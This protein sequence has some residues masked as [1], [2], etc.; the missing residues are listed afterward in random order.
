[1]IR[2]AACITALVLLA[3]CSDASDE[4]PAQDMIA[5]IEPVHGGDAAEAPQNSFGFMEAM[6]QGPDPF[7]DNAPTGQDLIRDTEIR[8]ASIEEASDES[9]QQVAQGMIAYAYSFGFQI[10]QEDIPALQQAHVAICEDLGP[11]CRILRMSQAGTDSYDGYGELQLQVDARQAREFGS[12]L[13]EPAEELGGEQVSFVVDGEDLSETIIDNEA[14]LA[15]RLV[16]RDKLTAILR[17]NRGSVDELVKAERAVAEVNEEIDST[18]SKLQELR[19]RIRFSSISISY[20]PAYGETQI[21]FVRPVVTAFKSIGSTLG[22][23]IGALIYLAT[24]LVPTLLFVL[25]LRWVWRKL[26]F[27][28]R[29]WRKREEAASEA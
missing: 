26:G 13:S 23:T 8:T 18:R 7:G 19:N 6:E 25:G 15:S 10:A 17:N 2:I 24:A 11:R 16:L 29:F 9:P 3:G 12:S 22:M 20:N 5:E 14:R 4:S 27:R 21:G 28:L 1:M